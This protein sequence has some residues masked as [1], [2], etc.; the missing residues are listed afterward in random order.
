VP[1]LQRG[2]ALLA[3]TAAMARG[4][5]T[6][7]LALALCLAVRIE[8]ALLRLARRML[9]V[10][11][12]A[13]VESDLW[14]SPLVL[15]RNLSG[16]VLDADALAALRRRLA[17][18]EGG[19]GF[20]DDAHA[21]VA[22]AHAG[23]PDALQLEERLVWLAVDRERDPT[24]A[25]E[26]EAELRAALKSLATDPDGGR[27]AATWVAQA[28]RRLPEAVLQTEAARLLAIGASLRIGS[29]IPVAGL[30][31]AT[32]PA[33]L[34][35]LAATALGDPVLVGVE[36]TGSALRFVEPA[37]DGDVLELPPTTPLLAEISSSDGTSTATRLEEIVV[38][39]E[40]DL[41]RLVGAITLRTLTGRTYTIEPLLAPGG[42]TGWQQGAARLERACVAVRDADG[43]FATGFFVAPDLVATSSG[44]DVAEI[45]WRE[46]WL[47]ARLRLRT[48]A[49]LALV[50]V[51]E[52]PS[53][54]EPLDLDRADPTPQDGATWVSR[55]YPDGAGLSV[56]VTGTVRDGRLELADFGSLPGFA[57][58]PV[59]VDGRV[60]GQVRSGPSDGWCDITPASE[61]RHALALA[62]GRAGSRAQVFISMSPASKPAFADQ[63]MQELQH[64]GFE[65]VRPDV[66]IEPGDRWRERLFEPLL[67]C[68]AAV[69]VF[70]R[71]ALGSAG[72]RGELD[73]LGLR[74][75][76]S[77]RFRLVP[78]LIENVTPEDVVRFASGAFADLQLLVRDDASAVVAR[79]QGLTAG[80]DR[81]VL[82]RRL[83]D[84]L[85]DVPEP[86]LARGPAVL[87]VEG[88][89]EAD[90]AVPLALL[91]RSGDPGVVVEF[92]RALR[93]EL[94]ALAASVLSEALRLL[95]VNPDAAAAMRRA[96]D[97]D[98]AVLVTGTSAALARTCAELAWLDGPPPA[99]VEVGSPP[100]GDPQAVIETV[101]ARSFPATGR[102]Q[103]A[104]LTPPLPPGPVIATLQ[105]EVPGT[106]LILVSDPSLPGSLLTPAIVDEL[107]MPLGVAPETETLAALRALHEVAVPEDRQR[108]RA[109]AR[110]A[111]PLERHRPLLRYDS[112][113][114]FFALSAAAMTDNV[115][116]SG[117]PNR[118]LRADGTVIASA[119]PL[120]DEPLLRLDFLGGTRYANGTPVRRNDHLAAADEAQLEASRRLSADPRYAN[121]IYGRAVQVRDQRWLQYWL[122]FYY[123][124]A[125]S[126]GLGRHEGDWKLI[127]LQLDHDGVPQ[128]ATYGAG[129]GASTWPWSALELVDGG[130]TPVV[131]VARGSHFCFSEPGT[132]GSARTRS[133]AD[134][135]GPEVRPSVEPLSR[136]TAWIF[137]PGRWGSTPRRLP[138][139]SP[140]PAGPASRREWQDPASFA[141]RPQET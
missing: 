31:A 13:G 100:D 54:A 88:V 124:D 89:G 27:W 74:M 7:E 25:P 131:Y 36:V 60:V 22:E 76:L 87:G 139:D 39:R 12:D 40:V 53:D 42:D 132:H 106:A 61:L 8:P 118:L 98:A 117:A 1:D 75:S 105:R 5:R 101:R 99:I 11:A 141:E 111:E 29:A 65:T 123:R 63:L 94:G 128:T 34:G 66:E 84:V 49:P 135:K 134:G 46:R 120:G 127:Q 28:W 108:P 48:T 82:L 55:A 80:P 97:R 69:V 35:W 41:G 44:L 121:R 85:R 104:V 70:S 16:L 77:A 62:R 93:P 91:E 79:L 68:D 57:G 96:A 43:R 83:R 56:A 32:L 112:Q 72:L 15:T 81:R 113:E 47:Q 21:L 6:V 140:S 4:E 14:F 51:L 125:T 95:L 59:L 37:A 38:G 17:D 138:T 58:A 114:A 33:S 130:T 129:A 67:T 92:A 20:A 133:R 18:G 86:A 90:L 73:V 107:G 24:R 30:E 3:R 23:Y 10:G 110:A 103:V 122:F 19:E 126:L 50:E 137:W 9:L 119:G 52:P 78:V 136:E 71:A 116:A 109:E 64:A 2:E 45:Q 26:L 102:K 115:S